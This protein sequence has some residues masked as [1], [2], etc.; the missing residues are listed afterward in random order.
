MSSPSQKNG[1]AALPAPRPAPHADE[2]PKSKEWLDERE[3]EEL[4]EL[5]DDLDDDRF[6]EQYR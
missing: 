5:E 2:Q 1:L 6:L 4:E 3:P